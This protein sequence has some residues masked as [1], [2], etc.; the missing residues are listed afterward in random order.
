EEDG[1]AQ[2]V[3][4]LRFRQQRPLAV[5]VAVH[6]DDH[7]PRCGARHV[8]R[9]EEEAERARKVPRLPGEAEGGRGGGIAGLGDGGPR[10]QHARLL[11]DRKSTRLNSSHEWI[12]YA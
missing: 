7:P 5:R 8:P 9:L 6:E 10:E 11:A 4:G 1:V 2:G 12:S 3:E